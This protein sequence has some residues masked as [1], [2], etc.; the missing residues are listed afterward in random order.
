MDEK[1]ED[2]VCAL[3]F[4]LTAAIDRLFVCVCII[5]NSPTVRF[6]SPALNSDTLH[7]RNS[8]VLTERRSDR[9]SVED[10]AFGCAA[11]GFRW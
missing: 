4:S 11:V 3:S 7:S 9:Y 8:G 6:T 5:L 1:V 10:A 2:S